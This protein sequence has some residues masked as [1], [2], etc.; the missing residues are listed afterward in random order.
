MSLT[1]KLQQVQMEVYAPK[2][3]SND[4][5]KFKY[6]SAEAIYSVVKPVG[7]KYGVLFTMT[8]EIEDHGNGLVYV[9]SI[10]RAK[11]TETDE[12]IESVAFA[13]DSL[14]KKGMDASQ[15]TGSA[16]SY[17]R[18]YAIC[19]LLLIDNEVDPDSLDNRPDD[20]AERA[21]I[22]KR[23]QGLCDEA[24]VG[25]APFCMTLFGQA[26]TKCSDSQLKA[27]ADR[28]GAAYKKYVQIEQSKTEEI[29]L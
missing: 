6:R 4:F 2:N 17:A 19:G 27:T 10:A 21:K 28:F 11:D 8:D 3:Q 25:I 13:R 22:I 9:K 15:A 18:K 20:N 14:E 23:L 26:V 5:G 1:Q 29:P 16:A 7:L 24:G 12:V